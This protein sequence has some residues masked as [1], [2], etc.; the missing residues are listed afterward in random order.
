MRGILLEFKDLPLQLSNKWM[1]F[2]HQMMNL[3]EF[4]AVAYANVGRYTL[5]LGNV[6]ISNVSSEW[7]C[8]LSA[9]E[10]PCW[11]SA[12]HLFPAVVEERQRK[13]NAAA[14]GSWHS[15]VCYL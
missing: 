9:K 6:K 1:V 15:E 3:E 13:A 10:K 5:L 4:I 14:L 2:K 7:L 11:I 12:Q 8:N